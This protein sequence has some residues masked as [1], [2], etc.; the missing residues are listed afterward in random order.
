[1]AN[2]K[3]T[4]EEIKKYYFSGGRLD[5]DIRP[6]LNLIEAAFSSN[7]TEQIVGM[8]KDKPLYRKDFSYDSTFLSTVLS[9][10]FTEDVDGLDIDRVKEIKLS[11]KVSSGTL[12][13][14][15]RA[16]PSTLS[17]FEAYYEADGIHVKANGTYA[18]D[19]LGELDIEILYI[20]T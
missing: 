11:A 17:G 14:T 18:I 2:S 1:M 16:M 8:W 9:G 12:Q 7:S 6:I 20:K 4:I 10:G 3:F 15:P 19:Q 13:F 5:Q